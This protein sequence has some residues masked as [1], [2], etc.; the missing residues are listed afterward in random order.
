MAGALNLKGICAQDALNA[1]L[2]A[3]WV[4]FT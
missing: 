2:A 4:L 1:I 3:L